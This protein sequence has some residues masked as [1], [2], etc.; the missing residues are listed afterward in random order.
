LYSTVGDFLRFGQMLAA[1]GHLDGHRVLAEET[2]AL[3]Y[4]NHLTAAQVEL[5]DTFMPGR[6]FGF[7]SA[8][9]LDPVRAGGTAG[10]HGWGGAATTTFWVDPVNDLV[11]V[12][13]AQSMLAP[14][15]PEHELRA[16]VQAALAA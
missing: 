10:E 13:M 6:G 7:G 3:M 4:D 12:L 5:F 16:I 8:V 14:D 15:T 9:V 11:G 2:V 1:G